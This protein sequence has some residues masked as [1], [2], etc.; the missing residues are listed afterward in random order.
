MVG[1]SS[2]RLFW[3]NTPFA[4]G[5]WKKDSH[6]EFSCRGSIGGERVKDKKGNV[7]RNSSIARRSNELSEHLKNP[8]NSTEKNPYVE[9]LV[10]RSSWSASAMLLY[11]GLLDA[12]GAPH[13]GR[14]S[15]KSGPSYDEVA[16]SFGRDP[17]V[18]W[19]VAPI[20]QCKKSEPA[21]NELDWITEE[22]NLLGFLA[23]DN[24]VDIKANSEKNE[25]P[26]SRTWHEL[27]RLKLTWCAAMIGRRRF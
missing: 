7:D 3:N 24:T 4:L 25:L 16:K 19:Y 17:S 5:T 1:V 12:T 2:V 10:R 21:P 8:E 18:G 23:V 14:A 26:A 11:P 22:R 15:A 27:A 20:T 13:A 6:A 9:Y